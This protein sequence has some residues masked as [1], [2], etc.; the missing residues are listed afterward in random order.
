MD[1]RVHALLLEHRDGG[2]GGEER[3]QRLGGL[4]ILG[5]G[6]DIRVVDDDLLQIAGLVG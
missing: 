4:G 6:G 3:D 5:A 2:L 1:G